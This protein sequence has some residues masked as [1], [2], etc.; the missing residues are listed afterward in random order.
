MKVEIFFIFLGLCL[1][2]FFIYVTASP[3]KIVLKYPTIDNIE[4]TTYI[5][6][7]GE[8]YKYYA[9]ETKCDSQ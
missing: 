7:A 3:P 4:Q 5:D 1:G 8:C 6:E 9:V 2:F